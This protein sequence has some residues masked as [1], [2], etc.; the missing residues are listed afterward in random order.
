MPL[1]DLGDLALYYKQHGPED[2]PACLGVMGFAAGY[3]LWSG[4]IPAVTASHR[5]VVFNNRGVGAS[6][7][8][9]PTSVDQMAD[10]A[11]RLLDHLGIDRCALFGI[12]MG[13]AI[14]QRL[15]LDHPERV[16]SL[17]LAMT[18]AR[19]IDFMRRQHELSRMLV[20]AG[21]GDAL[22]NG[23]LVRMF[24]PDFF[25]VGR[26]M[27]DQIVRAYLTSNGPKMPPDDVILAQLDLLDKHDT[28]AELGRISCATLVIGGK[29]DA[30]VPVLAAREIAAAIPRSK[31]V[32]F[33]TGHGAPL[34]EMD[35]F[36][37]T[38]SEFLSQ[39]P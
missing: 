19:P 17:I 35:A 39:H 38:V 10:D 34:Q 25:E 24:T 4:Q 23:I 9:A 7:G 36:N 16:S 1:A 15:V 30:M 20:A 8:G 26:E 27:V 2:A 3:Q 22:I 12:S 6:T 32:E 33:E 28:L 29:Q 21:G 31:Y 18:F 11:V 37:A 5:F 13:G 14:A